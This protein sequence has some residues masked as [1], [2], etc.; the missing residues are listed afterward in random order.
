MRHNSPGL[1]RYF[2][3]NVSHLDAMHQ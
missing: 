1:Q 2:F 3:G